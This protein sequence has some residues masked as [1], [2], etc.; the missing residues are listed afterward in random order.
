MLPVPITVG[1]MMKG[2]LFAACG[3]LFLAGCT[4]STRYVD[5]RDGS[6]VGAEVLSVTPTRIT[7]RVKQPATAAGIANVDATV[8]DGDVY[9]RDIRISSPVRKT[10]FEVDLSGLLLPWDWK[11][12]LYWVE[13]SSIPSPLNPFLKR[14]KTIER[15]KLAV[16]P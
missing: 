4:T 12:R 14:E 7:L 16:K 6:R 2:M 10:V 3:A 11:N 13:S 1:M 8:E 9:L 15:R 5:V